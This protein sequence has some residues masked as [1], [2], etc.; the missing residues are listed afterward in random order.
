MQM[1]GWLGSHSLFTLYGNDRR[2]NAFVPVYQE[3]NKNDRPVRSASFH[4]VPLST[5][6]TFAPLFFV[7][8][9]CNWT[10]ICTRKC[11]ISTHFW[12]A[13]IHTGEY[14]EL[15]LTFELR[16]YANEYKNGAQPF[17]K[18]PQGYDTTEY[19]YSHLRTKH[20]DQGSLGLKGP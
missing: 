3:V 1:L 15:W 5:G 11:C 20:E 17:V 10:Q 2:P 18:E 19:I 12:A 14:L 9:L 7:Y 13:G 6:M 4:P 8:S 16:Q